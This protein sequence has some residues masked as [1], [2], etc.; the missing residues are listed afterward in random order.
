M[1]DLLRLKT[2]V[3]FGNDDMQILHY[4]NYGRF[5]EYHIKKNLGQNYTKNLQWYNGQ[6]KVHKT[7]SFGHYPRPRVQ[8]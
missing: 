6:L 2:Q 5:F 8:L 1:C 7:F 4:R 3:L